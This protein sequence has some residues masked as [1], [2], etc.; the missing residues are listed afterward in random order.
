MQTRSPFFDEIARTMENAMGVAQ[1]AGEEA[2]AAV[3]AQADRWAAEL[4]LV[5][6]DEFDAMRAVLEGEIAALRVEIAQMKSA[7]AGFRPAD[8]AD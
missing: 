4:D 8:D 5:R 3:R 7:S 6:R 2:K 1:A